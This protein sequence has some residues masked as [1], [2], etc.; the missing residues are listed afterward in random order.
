MLAATAHRLPGALC[1]VC[2]IWVDS[3]CRSGTEWRLKTSLAKAETTQVLLSAAA[4]AVTQHCNGIARA[5]V[6]SRCLLIIIIML[7]I[8]P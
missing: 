1:F 3:R 5:D 7:P 8:K 4:H 2:Y 6:L